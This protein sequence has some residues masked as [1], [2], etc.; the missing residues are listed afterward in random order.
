[1]TTK[2]GIYAVL[3]DPVP[4]DEYAPDNR[5]RLLDIT[6]ASSADLA[7]GNVFDAHGMHRQ[8]VT[9]GRL[10]DYDPGDEGHAIAVIHTRRGVLVS[11]EIVP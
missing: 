4:D 5:G 3:T 1:M 9:T 8:I 2:L 11:G 6:I 7:A 10:G